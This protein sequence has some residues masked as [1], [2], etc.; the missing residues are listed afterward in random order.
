MGRS[1]HCS[2]EQRNLIKKLI[3]EGKTYKEVQ[4]IIGCSAKMISNALKWQQRPETRGRKRATTV[5]TDRRIVRMAKNQPI[6]T[7]RKIKDAIKLPVSA[8]RKS[9]INADQALSGGE[10]DDGKVLGLKV[11]SWVDYASD[12]PSSD[13]DPE[14]PRKVRLLHSPLEDVSRSWPPPALGEVQ[15]AELSCAQENGKD[16]SVWSVI[17]SGRG[18]GRLQIQNILT[19]AAGPTPLARSNIS[20]KLTAFMC[21]CDAVMLEHIRECSIA[22]ACRASEERATWDISLAELKAFIALLYV[23][24]AYCG[25]NIDVECFWSEQWGN[26]FFI[27]TLSRNRY[28]EI[29]RFLCFDRKETRRC[30]LTADRFA[31]LREVWDMFVSNSIACFRPGPNITVNE[32]LFPTKAR[33]PFSRYMPKRPDRFGIKF[34][35]ASDA[36]SKYMLNGF[37]YL[38]NDDCRSAMQRLEENVVLK[39]VEPFVDNGRNFIV[40]YITSHSLTNMPLSK[41]TSLVT[42]CNQTKGGVNGLDRMARQYSVKG[43]TRRWPVAAFYN[44]LDLAAI[45]AWVLYRQCMN[46]NI[47]RREFMLQLAQEL[48]AEWMASKKPLR[49][50]M[51]FADAAERRRMTCMIHVT[52]VQPGFKKEK[53]THGNLRMILRQTTRP[54]SQS[55]VR[56]LHIRTHEEHHQRGLVDLRDPPASVEEDHGT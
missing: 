4:Q 23:R 38:E 55:S 50:V 53:I 25:K 28:Q 20:D 8:E 1:K 54:L 43:G 15:A 30:R 48:R 12:G 34:W 40:N 21:L 9:V 18:A 36:Y 14:L 49:V 56:T 10:S 32:Q 33:C 3:G 5:K 7:S 19:E 45:N 39:L 17:E 46:E 37:P 11:E 41:D 24:G 29:M 2:G 47:S 16:G 22:E 44:V 51:P 31:P 26:A 27:S 42:Y 35:L 52:N 13:G 6:V